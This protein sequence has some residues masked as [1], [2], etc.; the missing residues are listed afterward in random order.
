MTAGGADPIVPEAE[1]VPISALQHLLYCPRRCAL[2]HI[3]RQ[4]S[5]NR[6]TAEGRLLHERADA[7]RPERRAG[8]RIER[9]VAVR[10][11][12]LGV[13]GVADVVEM[14]GD[15]GSPYPV[16]YKRGRPRGNR[17]DEVQL[18]AQALCL[19]EMLGG[20]VPEGALFYGRS[21]RRRVV[22]FDGE[23]R[24]LTERVARDVRRLINGGDTPAAIY[25][26]QKC[27]ACSLKELC[28][29]RRPAGAGVVGRWL[30]AEIDR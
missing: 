19:E 11:R 28:Q 9:S 14:R 8:V 7:G 1:L 2:I 27:E 12:R 5:E 29:P 25:E 22:V 15:D 17:A 6:F 24:E 23:L 3:E 30:A 21:R 16:E 13:S 10:S 20:L 26:P 18:C 4:W